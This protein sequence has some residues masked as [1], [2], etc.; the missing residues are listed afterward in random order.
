MVEWGEAGRSRRWI[1]DQLGCQTGT[2]TRAFKRLGIT[3]ERR[4]SRFTTK[5]HTDNHGYVLVWI[6]PE[7]PIFETA[8]PSR[9]RFP[10]GAYV[11]EHRVVMARHL[12]RSLLPPET[13]HQINR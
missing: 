7:D 4:M 6:R 11:L 8:A 1:A 13:L 12:G 5:D 10:T 2:I 3:P 9:R